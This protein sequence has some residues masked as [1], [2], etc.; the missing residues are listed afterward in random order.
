MLNIIPAV[1]TVE[2]GKQLG[3]DW[4]LVHMEEVGL[5]RSLPFFAKFRIFKYDIKCKLIDWKFNI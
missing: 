3:A 1:D 5:C 4:L 2:E